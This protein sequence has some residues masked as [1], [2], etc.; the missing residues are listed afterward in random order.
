MTKAFL[1]DRS[2]GAICFQSLAKD[3]GVA[4]LIQGLGLVLVYLS[5]VYLARWM[6]E[7]EYGI[8]EYVLSWTLLLATLASLGLPRTVLRFIAQYRVKQAWGLVRGIIRGSWWT[9]VAAG[10]V[11][12]LLGTIAILTLDHY[13][14][15]IYA[16][17]LLV[18]I[19]LIPLQALMNLQLETA[20]ALDDVTLAYAPSQIIW[21]VLVLGAG[22]FFLEEDHQVTSLPLVGSASVLLLAVILWQL[23]LLGQKLDD[24]VLPAPPV[25]A[26]REW[27]KVALVLLLQNAFVIVLQQTDIVMVGSILGPEQAGIYGAAVKTAMWVAVVL[28]TINMVAAPTFTMLYTQGDMK[29]L[30]TLVAAVTL[31]IFWPS[32]GI[33]LLLLTFAAPVMGWFGPSFVAGTWALKILI[34]GQL[35]SAFC[36]SV[37]Y[38]MA[39]TGHQNKSVIVFGS[40]A[41]INLTL[42]AFAIPIIGAVGAAM[43]TTFTM[44]IWNVWLSVLVVRYVG[45]S[46]SVFYQLFRGNSESAA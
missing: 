14:S 21:P 31:W 23:W 46:P 42:N 16:K 41:L 20:R 19:W 24:E 28:Q 2:S 36:G 38:L 6:G 15:F 10:L 8:Y 13:Y 12:A 25:Y 39:M 3:T 30:Q 7:T 32:L 35:V 27:M 11:V 18:G 4:I 45:V 37:G 33:A 44:V 17:P 5:R 34:L 26:H 43:T 22:F 1:S 29:G 40:A 9:T